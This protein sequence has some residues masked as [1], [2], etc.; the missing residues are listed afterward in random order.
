MRD[1]ASEQLAQRRWLVIQMLRAAGFALILIGILL[2]QGV[3]TLLA[4]G[5]AM[6]GY[7]LIVIGLLDGF[8]VPIILARKWRTPRQ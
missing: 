3:L 7:L 2:T 8:F 4:S 6:L 5:N 1:P